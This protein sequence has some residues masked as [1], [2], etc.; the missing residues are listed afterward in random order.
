MSVINYNAM[1]DAELRRYFLA[2][3]QD[4]QAL[5]AYLA[6]RQ[7]Q[8]RPVITHADDPEFE[9]KLQAAVKQQLAQDAELS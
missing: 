8:P 4:P 6:R 3:R 2:H 1:S 7:R 5:A 9:Q